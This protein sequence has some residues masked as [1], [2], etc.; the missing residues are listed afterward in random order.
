[1]IKAIARAFR[2]REQLENGM[3]STIAEIAR[4]ERINEFYVG[5]VV[6]LTLLAPQIVQAIMDGRQPP[7]MT[8]ATLMRPFSAAWQEQVNRNFSD[9]SRR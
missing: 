8:L 4:A 6:R 5:R 1:M 3:H 7:N 9:L 2:W